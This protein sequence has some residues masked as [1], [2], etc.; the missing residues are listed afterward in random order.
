MLGIFKLL[1]LTDRNRRVETSQN[2]YNSNISDRSPSNFYRCQINVQETMQKING[3]DARFPF[4]GVGNIFVESRIVASC[5]TTRKYAI[6]AGTRLRVMKTAFSDLADIVLSN[7]FGLVESI[8]EF[9]DRSTL[10][11]LAFAACLL[12]LNYTFWKL[13]NICRFLPKMA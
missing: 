1:A 6:S 11:V 7:E 13:W 4:N 9:E 10:Q 12:L 2:E 8:D 3:V 5:D